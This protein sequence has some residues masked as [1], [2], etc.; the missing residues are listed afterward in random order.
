[1]KSENP[2]YNKDNHGNDFGRNLI[3]PHPIAEASKNS[4]ILSDNEM[5]TRRKSE[6]LVKRVASGLGLRVKIDN[7][8]DLRFYCV[9][10][11]GKKYA[12]SLHQC[13]KSSV[14]NIQDEIKISRLGGDF[15]E[16]FREIHEI[17][18]LNFVVMLFPP[19]ESHPDFEVVLEM[20]I[21]EHG[22]NEDV[23]DWALTTFGKCL[24]KVTPLL[25]SKS[26]SIE[27]GCANG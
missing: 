24:K 6:R 18:S 13:W 5:L 3:K 12:C 21:C 26:E 16:R 7:V 22:F 14:F 2:I 11:R 8:D 25:K 9:I 15:K 17:C 19:I 10:Y 27:Y 1:M 4:K 20:G 23:L